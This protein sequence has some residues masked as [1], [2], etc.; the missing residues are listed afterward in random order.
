MYLCDLEVN[1]NKH[2]Y[3]FFDWN[4]SDKLI[5]LKKAPLY[6]VYNLENIINNQVKFSKEFLKEIENK[7]SKS[8]KYV[9]V[10]TN[11]SKFL[12]VSL[13]KNGFVKKISDINILDD[14]ELN[15]ELVNEQIK[16]VNYE[17]IETKNQNHFLTRKEEVIKHFF[18]KNL[19]NN[20]NLEQLKYI[21]YEKFNHKEDNINVIIKELK[22]ILKDDWDN[23]YLNIYNYFKII[24]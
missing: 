22:K 13:D 18:A 3:D 6:F 4:K 21:Y 7:Y 8:F 14:L 10:F 5:T 2:Y 23:N 12:V 19:N 9:C 11:K 15:Q 1:F 20:C 17:I 24:T 16:V